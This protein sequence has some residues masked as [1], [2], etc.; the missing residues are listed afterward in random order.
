MPVPLTLLPQ[1]RTLL[2]PTTLRSP[3]KLNL[4]DNSILKDQS[5]KESLAQRPRKSR[6]YK[7]TLMNSML[8]EAPNTKNSSKRLEN[9]KKLLLSSLKSEDSS[10]HSKLPHSSKRTVDQ[11]PLIPKLFPSS[12]RDFMKVPEELTS[13]ST[14]RATD[15]FSRSQLPSPTSHNNLL[16][17]V[18]SEESLT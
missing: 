5:F 12:K 16:T 8:I 14:E 11:R 7:G 2:K 15:N 1:I 9:T 4:K 10:N 13:S 17:K 3:L 18:T 6:I